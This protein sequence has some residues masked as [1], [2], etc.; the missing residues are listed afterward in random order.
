MSR[1]H[2]H[3]KWYRGTYRSGVNN[4]SCTKYICP[5]CG[6]K[7]SYWVRPSRYEF[8]LSFH[9]R[10]CYHLVHEVDVIR[11]SYTKRKA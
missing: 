8:V 7:R 9:C 10:K 1:S 11:T 6:C 5:S 4:K 3:K 2:N